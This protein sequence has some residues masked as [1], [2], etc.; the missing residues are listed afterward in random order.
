L[1][2]AGLRTASVRG[3]NMLHC[4]LPEPVLM[5]LPREV[6]AGWRAVSAIL[7]GVDAVVARIPWFYRLASTRLVVA[8]KA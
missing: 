8:V 6:G 1:A 4:L 3:V 7:Q 2:A 5:G